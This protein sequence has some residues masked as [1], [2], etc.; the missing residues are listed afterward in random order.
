MDSGDARREAI[1]DAALGVFLRYGWK[2]TSMDDLARAA[3]LSRQGLYL[4][5]ATKEELFKAVVLRMTSAMLNGARAALAREDLGVEE[6]V[7][8]AF[9]AVHG[10][11]IGV[12]GLEHGDELIE[13]AESLV[14]PVVEELDREI[15]SG[16]ARVLKAAGVADAWKAQGVSAKALAENLYFTSYGVKHQVRSAAEYS[17]RMR[18]AIL[19]ACRGH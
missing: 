10:E 19:I 11:K 6:R 7:L 1:L 14:G 12:S 3:E 15:I 13:A 9:Q 5:F 16:I 17:E 8:G 18:V 2:K 4:H